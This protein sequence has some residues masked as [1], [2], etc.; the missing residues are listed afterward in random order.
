M[1]SG[2]KEIV[3]I[4]LKEG[5]LSS[6]K[7]AQQISN[8]FSVIY[9]SC[10]KT[11]N[12]ST[13]EEVVSS[14]SESDFWRGEFSKMVSDFRVVFRRFS[15]EINEK[16]LQYTKQIT[17]NAGENDVSWAYEYIK[18]S[19]ATFVQKRR[20][21]ETKCKISG[22]DLLLTTQFFTDDYMVE[23]IVDSVFKEKKNLVSEIVFVDPA[24]GGGNFL[25]YVAKKLFRWY[26][27]K[28][29]LEVP[30]I[31]EK[32][33]N[34]QIVGYDLDPNIAA[35]A[36]LS[37][38]LQCDNFNKGTIVSPVILGGGEADSLGYLTDNPKENTIKKVVDS[39]RKEGKA[40]AF[41]TNPPFMGGRDLDTSVKAYLDRE[42]P[43]GMGDLCASFMY[44]MMTEL[45]EGDIIGSVL[46]NS[47]LFLSSYKNL[48]QEFLNQ[49]ELIK[50][51]DLGSH[52]F[53]DISGEKANVVL[54]LIT[55][56][57]SEKVITQFINLRN[58]DYESKRDIL[59]GVN[60][61]IIE[62]DCQRFREVDDYAFNYELVG[63]FRSKPKKMYG[64]FAH[65]MQ[66]TSTGDSKN[67]VKYYWEIPSD[68]V[69]WVL[70]SKG[71]GFSKWCGLNYYKV[72][73]GKNGD[74]LRKNPGCALRNIFEIPETQL[75]YSDTGTLG[76]NVRKKR[77]D[78]VFIASGPGIHTLDGYSECHLAFLNSKFATYWL[79][80]SN[81][82][83][84]V[85]AGY[86]ARIP[87]TKSILHSKQ[88]KSLAE[89]CFS[90][91]KHLIETKVP[92]I[93]CS[94][95]DYHGIRDIDKYIESA[96]ISDLSNCYEIMKAE[97][98]ID[99]LIYKSLHLSKRVVK[100]IEDYSGDLTHR[101]ELNVE[102]LDDALCDKIDINCLTV[103][104]K[105]CGSEIGS[106]N[107]LALVCAEF[108]CTPEECYGFSLNNVQ[109]LKKL[110]QRY[111][112][113]FKHKVLLKSVGVTRLSECK[114][115]QVSSASIKHEMKKVCPA[116][117]D[118]SDEEIIGIIRHHEKA[119][120]DSPLISL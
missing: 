10:L 65:I 57:S 81:P 15:K 3:A 32:I 47:W 4:L 111:L 71:G 45:K 112:K 113:D 40:I 33:Y 117:G 98:G 20:D 110:K 52:A 36:K 60:Q 106:D 56:K 29:T 90:C 16:I 44:R 72:H 26:R 51:A 1:N 77:E 114:P 66:G 78:Q 61:D 86:I 22:G 63:V 101:K 8:Y 39:R 14:I 64:D 23:Y 115:L 85:S 70:V 89:Q 6:L 84:T 91:K 67:A 42:L 104:T 41:V 24:C 118:I 87:V 103:G 55:K 31:L 50:C 37:L 102:A 94:L 62:V 76:L 19:L 11:P 69:D 17:I 43:F 35:I 75:V 80:V 18:A 30:Q 9:A 107:L 108:G 73:W 93:E 97:A 12:L 68:N 28:T 38:T 46:Q 105:K 59:R 119:F 100:T 48:R 54:A 120:F 99:R 58:K 92:N 82:K 49:Y 53:A 7:D 88:L 83:L 5:T 13:F 25:T 109:K 116:M 79:K 96:I 95:P 21:K 2:I 74:A 34:E 27:E